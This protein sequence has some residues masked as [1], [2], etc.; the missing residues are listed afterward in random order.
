MT[1]S[2]TPRL[3]L[4][5]GLA[6]AAVAHVWLIQH[7]G[8]NDTWRRWHI[9]AR[10]PY[11]S[12]LRVITGAG[13]SLDRGFNPREKNP[14][15]PFSQL[16]NQT[17]VWLWLR[18]LGI[19]EADSTVIGAIMLVGYAVG[20]WWLCAGIDAVGALLLVPLI[21]SPATL[22]AV[23]RGTTDLSVFFLL[24]LAAH[25]AA[26]AMRTTAAAVL[27]AFVLKLFPLA[28]VVLV[29]REPRDRAIRF[30]VI[31][32]AIAVL[33][34][35]LDFRE[36]IDIGFKT[37][38]G[39]HTSYGWAVLSLHL[40]TL[41]GAAARS[42]IL[43]RCFCGAVAAVGL[44][45]VVAKAR[46]TPDDAPPS[47]TLDFFRVGAAVY[48]GTFA[49]GASWDYRLIFALFLVPQLVAWARDPLSDLRILAR[50]LLVT[51]VVAAWSLAFKDWL[52]GTLAG[53][54]AGRSLEEFAKW[55]LFFGCAYLLVRTLP[56][57]LK[58]SLISMS[59]RV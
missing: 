32:L 30:G 44:G 23:E 20:L 25:L 13:D 29:L 45:L 50:S 22:L 18:D 3:W 21:L 15:A 53:K 34:C 38:K 5:L 1:R 47:S 37:E 54:I 8:W 40:G 6:L 31:I 36:L 10:S 42:A 26:R 56:A 2:L 11:F 9:D 16:F 28:G 59:L 33:F 39:P 17:F 49:L 57:W 27:A 24:A 7:H 52:G 48:A 19:R 55:S 43:V 58:R 51:L 4:F 14:G 46:R 41:G 35:A 12:D